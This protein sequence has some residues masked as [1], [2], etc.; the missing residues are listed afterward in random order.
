MSATRSSTA[1]LSPAAYNVLC[2]V[3]GLPQA[4]P[5]TKS[6][7]WEPHQIAVNTGVMECECGALFSLLPP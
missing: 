1:K 3:C 2:P 4:E 7:V 5:K 6:I